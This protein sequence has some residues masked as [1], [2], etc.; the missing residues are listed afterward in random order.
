ML[1]PVDIRDWAVVTIVLIVDR[2]KAKGIEKSLAPWQT[3]LPFNQ[4]VNWRFSIE[5]LMNGVFKLH[6]EQME[7]R[8]SD[9][10]G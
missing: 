3:H 5:R 6:V 2:K 1:F 4:V 10:A 8:S 9:V 7:N